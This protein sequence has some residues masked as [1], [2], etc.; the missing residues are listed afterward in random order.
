MARKRPRSYPLEFR[1]KIIE[2]ARSWAPRQTLAPEF[3]LLRKQSAIGSSKPMWTL[4]AAAT[5]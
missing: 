3:N 4:V 2:L 1:Q 5:A